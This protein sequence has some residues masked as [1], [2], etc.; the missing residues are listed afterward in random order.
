MSATANRFPDG[1]WEIVGLLETDG[2][3]Q[4]L[5][6]GRLTVRGDL[7]RISTRYGPECGPGHRTADGAFVH[8]C[9]LLMLFLEPTTPEAG[10]LLW[11]EPSGYTEACNAIPA[12][13][14]N[15]R[16]TVSCRLPIIR[17]GTLKLRRSLP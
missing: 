14:T 17:R 13:A 11:Q 10:W 8:E 16:A 12:S 15:S 6:V 1:V 5:L 9:G 3:S 2:P 4:P 7:S